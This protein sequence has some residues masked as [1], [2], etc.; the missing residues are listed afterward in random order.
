M[1]GHLAEIHDGTEWKDIV[2]LFKD[3]AE[4]A[5]TEHQHEVHNAR[6]KRE[7]KHVIEQRLDYP[8]RKIK[9]A[10]IKKLEEVKDQP[11][12]EA[13]TVRRSKEAWTHQA[14]YVALCVD[15]ASRTRNYRTLT[16]E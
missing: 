1:I 13:A 8:T 16:V 2:T 6:G 4:S 10:V 9:T 15:Q 7:V 3:L 5:L 11:L 12:S 14:F